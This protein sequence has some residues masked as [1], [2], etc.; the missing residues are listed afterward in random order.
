MA[1]QRWEGRSAHSHQMAVS[2]ELVDVSA[3][4]VTAGHCPVGGR[5]LEHGERRGSGCTRYAGWSEEP[6]RAGRA[7]PR[8]RRKPPLPCAQLTGASTFLA[9]TIASRQQ[10]ALEAAAIAW[11]W[12]WRP[13]RWGPA[14]GGLPFT[15]DPVR[16]TPR[17]WRTGCRCSVRTIASSS[18]L[19]LMRRKRW[20]SSTPSQPR[21][22]LAGTIP[23]PQNLYEVQKPTKSISVAPAALRNPSARKWT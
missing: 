10:P 6:I 3:D 19:P 9:E 22:E 18:R 13:P 16:I 1:S 5:V 23:D 7:C 11:S 15:P 21:P 12:P 20:S 14:R 4:R 8:T 17:S 2:H